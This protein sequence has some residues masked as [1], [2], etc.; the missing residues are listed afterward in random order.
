[1][2]QPPE[3]AGGERLERRGPDRTPFPPYRGGPPAPLII[4]QDAARGKPPGPRK[5]APPPRTADLLHP[6]GLP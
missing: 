5:L 1:L 4:P 3:R 6:F 2:S